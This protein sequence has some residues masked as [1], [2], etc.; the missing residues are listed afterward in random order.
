MPFHD[1]F[2]G[3][4]GPSVHTEDIDPRWMYF[5]DYL[6]DRGNRQKLGYAYIKWRSF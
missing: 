6:W 4:A 3:S 5:N 2:P 1:E